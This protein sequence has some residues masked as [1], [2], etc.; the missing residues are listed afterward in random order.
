MGPVLVTGWD[1][2]IAQLR[3]TGGDLLIA[4]GECPILTPV[5]KK[6]G[7][8]GCPVNQWGLTDCPWGM[9]NFNTGVVVYQ[10]LHIRRV[11]KVFGV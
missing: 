5:G 6:L 3:E 11:Q 1:L 8:T 2:L 4:H 7:L 10:I 9:P